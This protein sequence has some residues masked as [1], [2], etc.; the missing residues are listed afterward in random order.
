[1]YEGWFFSYLTFNP[2]SITLDIFFQPLWS[3]HPAFSSHEESQRDDGL[4]GKAG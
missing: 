3:P 4:G 1:M 2:P